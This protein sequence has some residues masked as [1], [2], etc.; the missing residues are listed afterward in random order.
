MM[1]KTHV[2]KK[3]TSIIEIELILGEITQNDFSIIEKEIPSNYLI[4]DR[5]NRGWGIVILNDREYIEL[6]DESII[7][8]IEPLK[9]LTYII[10]KYSTILRIAVY[11]STLTCTLKLNIKETLSIFNSELEIS[12]YPTI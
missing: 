8:F 7:H 2:N 4:E 3:K 5:S 6:I 10:S 1:F 11:C 9:A 12:I